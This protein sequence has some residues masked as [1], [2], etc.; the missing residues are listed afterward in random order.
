MLTSDDLINSKNLL[1]SNSPLSSPRFHVC[2]IR[3]HL[4]LPWSVTMIRPFCFVCLIFHSILVLLYLSIASPNK[5]GISFL[6]SSNFSTCIH[7]IYY[8]IP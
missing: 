2:H 1:V 5:G 6:F 8:Q 4:Y 7:L 3:I